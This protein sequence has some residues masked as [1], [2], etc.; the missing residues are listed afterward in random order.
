MVNVRSNSGRTRRFSR[1]VASILV[2]MMMITLVFAPAVSAEGTGKSAALNA[3]VDGVEIL[4]KAFLDKENRTLALIGQMGTDGQTMLDGGV[5]LTSEALILESIS[6]LGQAYGVDLI[7]YAENLA[8]S[9]FAPDSGSA[10]AMD[11]ETFAA[12]Q[13]NFKSIVSNSAGKAD[14]AEYNALI[15][16]L[17]DPVQILMEELEQPIQNL[18]T[19]LQ[20]GMEMTMKTRT[21]S[22]PNGNVNASVVTISLGAEALGNLLNQ[23]FADV[24]RSKQAKEAVGQIV[25]ILR[26][27]GVLTLDVDLT[28]YSGAQLADILWK[29]LPELGRQASDS[30]TEAGVNVSVSTAADKFTGETVSVGVSFTVEDETMSVDLRS[31]NGIYGLEASIPDEGNAAIWLMLATEDTPLTILVQEEGEELAKLTF[32]MDGEN[33]ILTVGDSV[34]DMEVIGSVLKD[35][36]STIITLDTVDGESLGDISLTLRS[37]DSIAIPEFAEIL[38]LSEAEM[39][40]LVELV[41]AIAESF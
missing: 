30:I 21:I 36:A 5:Y 28:A 14:M 8:A 32:R 22:L 4:A 17:V 12:L 25:D 35:D 10:Y 11:K 15:E 29:K 16:K 19:N 2:V 3:S 37:N 39:D 23:F 9:V 40:H 38:T 41:G 18:S 31:A 6:M 27:G 34:D 24:S 7:H 1:A 33:W 13:D 20:N 26:D